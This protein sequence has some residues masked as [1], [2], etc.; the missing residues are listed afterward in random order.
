MFLWKKQQL[1]ELQETRAT[2]YYWVSLVR[3]L[4]ED[5]LDQVDR[6]AQSKPTATI[7]HIV[8]HKL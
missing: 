2:Q 7:K 6:I 4:A 8:N 5:L 1:D 3:F